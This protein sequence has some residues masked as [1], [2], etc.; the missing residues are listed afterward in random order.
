[1][2]LQ[3]IFGSIADNENASVSLSTMLFHPI[4]L[5]FENDIPTSYYHG[6]KST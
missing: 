2:S 3:S 5:I 6:G 4:D 1:M